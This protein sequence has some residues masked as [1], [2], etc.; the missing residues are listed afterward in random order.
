MCSHPSRTSARNPRTRY[1]FC[2]H[3]RRRLRQ[4]ITVGHGTHQMRGQIESTFS[5]AHVCSSLPSDAL[6]TS[7]LQDRLWQFGAAMAALDAHLRQT[8]L[9]SDPPALDPCQLPHHLSTASPIAAS[10]RGEAG[11]LDEVFRETAWLLLTSFVEHACFSAGVILWVRACTLICNIRR[12]SAPISFSDESRTSP[13][14]AATTKVGR[15]SNER[16][17]PRTSLETKTLGSAP[18]LPATS[19]APLPSATKIYMAIVYPL[20]LRPLAGF[21]MIWDRQAAILNTIEILVATMQFVALTAVLEH[22]TLTK[23][24]GSRLRYP[25]GAAATAVMAGLF[26]KL[27]ARTIFCEYLPVDCRNLVVP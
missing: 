1:T 3:F 15:T 11:D 19:P 22:H 10:P 26:V 8:A 2:S 17:D 23:P 14:E 16:G 13:D 7:P 25:G 4:K 5:S 20:F 6:V 21:V 24:G 27:I 12:S 18:L 9:F